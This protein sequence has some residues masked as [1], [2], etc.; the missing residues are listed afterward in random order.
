VYARKEY[1]GDSWKEI[2]EVRYRVLKDQLEIYN[3]VSGTSLPLATCS[4]PT[5]D[6]L[7]W[8]IWLYKDVGFQG[9]THVDSESPYLKLLKDFLLKK[10]RLAV[11]AWGSDISKVEHVYEVSPASLT[12]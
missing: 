4:Q 6:R 2:N 9:M 11:D 8:T 5:Q 7:S 1:E 3:K 12:R 10:Q